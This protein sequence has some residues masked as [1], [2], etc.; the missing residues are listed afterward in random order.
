MLGINVIQKDK[1]D[2]LNNLLRDEISRTQIDE[3]KLSA[4]VE[5]GADGV[6]IVPKKYDSGLF[7]AIDNK[8]YEYL[9]LLVNR[10]GKENAE[11][12]HNAFEYATQK[13]DQTAAI[14]LLEFPGLKF[15]RKENQKKTYLM[16][17]AKSGLVKVAKSL[18][19]KRANMHATDSN[20][21][22]V[23]DY[24]KEGKNKEM[25]DYI[26]HII[27]KDKERLEKIGQKLT[28]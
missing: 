6:S 8:Y 13:K 2:N 18:I 28:V 17:V 12:I 23:L 19:K 5:M 16:F 10:I 15:S 7:Y 14:I 22:S 9:K 25:I 3:Y 21:K 11:L 4:L 27:K 24:A 26:E 1:I 20:G